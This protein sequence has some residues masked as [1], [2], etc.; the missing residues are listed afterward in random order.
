MVLPLNLNLNLTLKYPLKEFGSV[1]INAI[2]RPNKPK[3]GL[4]FVSNAPTIK[5]SVQTHPCGEAWENN[6]GHWPLYGKDCC[7]LCPTNFWLHGLMQIQ[8]VK[9]S[10]T[11][12]SMPT[13]NC[14]LY[15]P[16][17]EVKWMDVHSVSGTCVPGGCVNSLRS[18]AL[19][20]YVPRLS[21]MHIKQVWGLTFKWKLLWTL[22]GY[23][24]P[25]AL[26]LRLTFA[27]DDLFGGHVSL[28]WL[29]NWGSLLTTGY[30]ECYVL[31]WL[32]DSC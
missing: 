12:C 19:V 11:L 29:Y 10:M 7:R 13:R 20:L 24:E 4:P 15:F 1:I 28:G 31:V 17:A 8:C 27:T 26:Q 14:F 18:P 9:Y 30:L 25:V 3:H 23:S 32:R 6:V 5:C 2:M 21:W 22:K 16:P